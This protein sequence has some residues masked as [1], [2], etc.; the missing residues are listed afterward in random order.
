MCW[1][2][3]NYGDSEQIRGY[4][5]LGWTRVDYKGTAKRNILEWQNFISRW[6]FHTFVKTHSTVHQKVRILLYVT[7]LN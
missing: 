6:W 2:T 1:K 3:Q 7:F 5:G 4:Q